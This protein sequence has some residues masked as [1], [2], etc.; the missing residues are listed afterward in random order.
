[1]DRASLLA[2]LDRYGLHLRDGHVYHQDGTPV[3]PSLSSPLP[4]TSP[5]DSALSVSQPTVHIASGQQ[6]ASRAT[7]PLAPIHSLEQDSAPERVVDPGQVPQ[8][9]KQDVLP[10]HVLDAVFQFE[11]SPEPVSFRPSVDW[12]S[13]AVGRFGSTNDETV[14]RSSEVESR[15]LKAFRFGRADE[16]LPEG[17]SLAPPSIADEDKQALS[18]SS[19]M[20][21][22]VELEK[23]RF[24]YQKKILVA[25]RPL[26]F[27]MSLLLPWAFQFCEE[28]VPL[29]PEEC[30]ARPSDREFGAVFNAIDGTLSLLSSM[31]ADINLER[32]ECI[33]EALVGTNTFKPEPAN[34]LISASDREAILRAA[35]RDKT[36]REGVASVRKANTPKPKSRGGGSG[37]HRG[38]H[39]GKNYYRGAGDRSGQQRFDSASIADWVSSGSYRGGPRSEGGTSFRGRSFGGQRG[40]GNNNSFR[41]PSS[42]PAP[43]Q[44]GAGAQ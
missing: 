3:L 12:T 21:S 30:A 8:F 22:A 39:S 19:K 7:A 25:S 2:L 42:G 13:I 34:T 20:T 40:S 27:S 23:I 29:T 4:L 11:N 37:A 15:L 36:F 1:M 24:E 41:K 17:M 9:P 16:H 28:S 38:A 18:R 35:K 6:E 33:A 5:G 10:P 43:H 31:V 26:L 44:K 32:K 14:K